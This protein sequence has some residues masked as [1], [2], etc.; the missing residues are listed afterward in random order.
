[1]K[2]PLCAEPEPGVAACFSCG[3]ITL[4]P[5]LENNIPTEL[6]SAHEGHDISYWPSLRDFQPE[7]F[8]A[9]TST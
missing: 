1:M 8:V 9:A 5:P 3:I 6:M 2:D 4:D 7:Y